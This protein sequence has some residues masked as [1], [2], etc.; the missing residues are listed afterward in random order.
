MW[1]MLAYSH[2][3]LL[4]FSLFFFVSFFLFLFSSLFS[5][6]LSLSFSLFFLPFSLF[7]F[8]IIFFFF[9]GKTKVAPA[10]VWM[11][12]I[13]RCSP[14]PPPTHTHTLIFVS[15]DT[16]SSVR[17]WCLLQSVLHRKRVPRCTIDAAPMFLGI[18]CPLLFLILTCNG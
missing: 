6:F 13:V 17:C 9:F 16:K 10:L 3:L 12:L 11:D 8:F 2:S 14:T 5:L 7:T 18:V 1:I 15:Y 4:H